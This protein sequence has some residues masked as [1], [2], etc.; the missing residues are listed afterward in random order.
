MTEPVCARHRFDCSVEKHAEE[1]R[2][3][4]LRLRAEVDRLRAALA[5][6]TVN[7]VTGGGASARRAA[8]E[9]EPPAAEVSDVCEIHRETVRDLLEQLAAVK[10]D[11]A[12]F[13]A[14]AD[15]VIVDLRAKLRAVPAPILA[16]MEA[17]ARRAAGPAAP[18]A[19]ASP[20]EVCLRLGRIPVRD[21]GEGWAE[22]R[23]TAQDSPAET[24]GHQHEYGARCALPAGHH[25]LHILNGWG[26]HGTYGT[27]QRETAQDSGHEPHR[28]L[29]E[30]CDNA[31][32]HTYGSR[33]CWGSK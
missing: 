17:D 18:I 24:C 26:W 22:Q 7:L 30:T 29:D 9:P 6:H 1:W 32:P 33:D 28:C 25:G 31:K 8:G 15:E 23:E 2:D 21:E 16:L 14:D 19:Q 4:A 5:H 12:Q 3:E 11:Y 13:V 20:A 27:S 10:A